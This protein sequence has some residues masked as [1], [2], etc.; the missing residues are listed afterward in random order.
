MCSCSDGS[1]CHV[2]FPEPD[3]QHD[4]TASHPTRHQAEFLS[5]VLIPFSSAGL[6]LFHPI[7]AII[8]FLLSCSSS[9]HYFYF[10][11]TPLLNIS[12]PASL[13]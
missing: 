11:F 3:G 12:F 5:L 8:F 13:S 2:E 1:A 9:V 4:I 10:F 6:S 7:L